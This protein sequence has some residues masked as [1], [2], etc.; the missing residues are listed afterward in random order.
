MLYYVTTLTYHG[1]YCKGISKIYYALSRN[2]T[3]TATKELDE[4]IDYLSE[5]ENEIHL[6]F[7]L[8]LFVRRTRQLIA[9]KYL[10]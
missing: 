8:Y 1:E 9:G 2:D 7:D 10:G 6:Y 4:L 3:E 5:V